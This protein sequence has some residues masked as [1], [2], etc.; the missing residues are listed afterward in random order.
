[1]L[2]LLKC[3]KPNPIPS[4]TNSLRQRGSLRSLTSNKS[5]QS[6]LANA[7]KKLKQAFLL[8]KSTGV[9]PAKACVSSLSTDARSL[10]DLTEPSTLEDRI[11]YLHNQNIEFIER[12]GGGCFSD[13]YRCRYITTKNTN[14]NET[15]VCFGNEFAVKRVNLKDRKNKNFTRKFLPR[16]IL[17]HSTIK[18]DHVAQ[19]MNTLVTPTDAYLLMEYVEKKNLFDYCKQ[20]GRLRPSKCYTV[21]SQVLSAIEYLHTKDIVHRDIKCENIIFKCYTPSP[22]VKLIDF[23]FAKRLGSCPSKSSRQ[24]HQTLEQVLS[25]SDRNLQRSDSKTSGTPRYEP[26]PSHLTTTFCGSLAYVAPEMLN[27]QGAYDPKRTDIWSFG[28]V[29]YVISTHRMPFKESQGIKSLK[30][31]VNSELVWPKDFRDTLFMSS[32]EKLLERDPAKRVIAAHVANLKWFRHMS[33]ILNES[34]DSTP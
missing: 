9:Q 16:E 2:T 23:G 13:I 32:L 31:Q 26:I 5:S 24:V 29:I 3:V 27:A 28:V 25:D 34:Y 6:S 11:F 10:L 20:N 7:F 8:S 19:Y 4:R 1:M 14:T 15:N 30:K 22:V 17:I 21:A 18:H 33:A 12:A